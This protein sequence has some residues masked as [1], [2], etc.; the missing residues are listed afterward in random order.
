MIRTYNI[1]DQHMSMLEKHV[2]YLKPGLCIRHVD[3]AESFGI[4]IAVVETKVTVLWTH[5]PD[6]LDSLAEFYEQWF[7]NVI[8]I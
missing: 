5:L 2:T 4:V 7:S 3:D 8:R 6:I 1:E